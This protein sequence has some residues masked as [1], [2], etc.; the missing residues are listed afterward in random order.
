MILRKLYPESKLSVDS[1][2]IK[3]LNQW[4]D[5]GANVDSH[6]SFMPIEKIEIPQKESGASNRYFINKKLKN[7]GMNLSIQLVRKTYK[8]SDTVMVCHHLRMK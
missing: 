2:E 4:V 7:N 1:D 8:T 3:I 6:W 5:S